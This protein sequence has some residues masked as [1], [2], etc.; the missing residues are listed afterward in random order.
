MSRAKAL[1]LRRAQG[2]AINTIEITGPTGG[3]VDQRRDLPSV[4]ERALGTERDN[5]SFFR[6]GRR[7]GALMGEAAKVEVLQSKWPTAIGRLTQ[8]L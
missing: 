1:V 8:G 3:S 4:D 5:C 7:S 6:V 2:T